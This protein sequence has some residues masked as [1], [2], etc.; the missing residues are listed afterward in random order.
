MDCVDLEKEF[1]LIRFEKKEDYDR[2][3]KGGFIGEHF[4]FVKAWEPRFRPSTNCVSSIAVWVRLLELPI[5][6]YDN[7]ILTEIGSTIGPV[8]RIDSNTTMEAR[9]RLL[10]SMSRLI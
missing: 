5:E 7:E 2:V 9:G 1:F 10:E 6:Y 8:L 3:L 4:L